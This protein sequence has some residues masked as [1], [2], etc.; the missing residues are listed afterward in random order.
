MREG[1]TPS[2]VIVYTV[3]QLF[4]SITKM[5]D[6]VSGSMGVKDVDLAKTAEKQDAFSEN[7]TPMANDEIIDLSASV[8]GT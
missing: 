2:T 5:D 4:Q 1:T 7:C 8:T 3:H 6:Y